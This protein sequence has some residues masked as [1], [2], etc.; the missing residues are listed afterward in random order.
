M[1]L[2][3]FLAPPVSSD[4]SLRLRKQHENSVMKRG[5][6]SASGW[7][8]SGQLTGTHVH[9]R[10]RS[11]FFFFYVDV[12]VVFCFCF[13]SC[14]YFFFCATSALSAYACSVSVSLDCCFVESTDCLTQSA[15][16]SFF[17]KMFVF[18]R[19]TLRSLF[20]LRFWVIFCQRTLIFSI[21]FLSFSHFRSV[22]C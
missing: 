10:S 9:T 4:C 22:N 2:S 15:F 19:N 20:L 14:F 8:I 7:C 3:F 12:V 21:F 17:S 16:F 11:M 13:F 1:S 6:Q 5:T 18:F